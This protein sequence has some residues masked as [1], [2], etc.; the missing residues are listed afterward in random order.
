MKRTVL[1]LGISLLLGFSPIVHSAV[2]HRQVPPLAL[3]KVYNDS[4]NINDYWVS[5]KLDGARAYWNGK[6]LLSRSGVVFHA[7]DWFTQGLPEETLDGELW[8]G[9]GSFQSLMQVVRD[10]TP[11][12]SAWREVRYWVFDLPAAL[13]PFSERQRT[14]HALLQS[15]QNPQLKIVRQQRVGSHAQLQHL[16]TEM[17]S[18][19]AEGLILQRED[20][21]Y[22]TGRHAG[23]LKLKTHVDDEAIVVDHLPGKGKY[24]GMLGALL[25]EDAQGRMFRLG[26]GLS[27]AQR[28]VP[29]E[30]GS[31][32]SYRYQGR[33]DK[34]LP[35]FARF[36][37]LRPSGD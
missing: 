13:G 6:Q 27:D 21:E 23:V 16:L 24:Q 12:E 20:R 7:P 33:T 22:S 30:R 32:V 1:A 19:G 9:R 18:A 3:S 29:P 34:G 35:R 15:V 11:D 5:E 36:L 25:V 26:S 8:M 4:I 10:K 31:R 17:V 28:R 2:E 37:R 14:L